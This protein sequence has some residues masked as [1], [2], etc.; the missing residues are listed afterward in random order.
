MN[1]ILNIFLGIIGHITHFAILK[2]ITYYKTDAT[3]GQS[4][5]ETHADEVRRQSLAVVCE[6]REKSVFISPKTTSIC[7]PFLNSAWPRPAVERRREELHISP[8]QSKHERNVQTRPHPHW[9]HS[10]AD[11]LR[12]CFSRSYCNK[13]STRIW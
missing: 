2:S 3:H 13:G 10:N 1:T 9:S 8:D 12:H 11:W 6:R 4:F 7:P 5:Q